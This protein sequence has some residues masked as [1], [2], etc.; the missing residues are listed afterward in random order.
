MHTRRNINFSHGEK[1]LFPL[2]RI[3]ASASTNIWGPG[4]YRWLSNS[5]LWNALSFTLFSNSL[6]SVAGNVKKSS[7]RYF[8]MPLVFGWGYEF[9]SERVNLCRFYSCRV[10]FSFWSYRCFICK[11]GYVLNPQLQSLDLNDFSLKETFDQ[12]A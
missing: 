2:S 8:L 12:W 6:A 3:F 10:F 11:Y 1:H 4:W 9:S 7:I 5:Y